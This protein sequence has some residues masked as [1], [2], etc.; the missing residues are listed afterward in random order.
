MGRGVREEVSRQ[1]AA[2]LAALGPLEHVL[3]GHIPPG[4]GK[5]VGLLR[6]VPP[7]AAERA[8]RGI[9]AA[10][11]PEREGL[12]FS[13]LPKCYCLYRLWKSVLWPVLFVC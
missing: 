3:S 6:A 1:F 13:W 12:Y 2:S 5:S 10:I 7:T 11:T 8:P 9:L 4:S